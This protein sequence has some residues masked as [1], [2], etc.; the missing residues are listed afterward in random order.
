MTALDVGAIIKLWPPV[1][2][3]R[4]SASL[5]ILRTASRERNSR[6]AILCTVVSPD[7]ASSS[8]ERLR[9]ALDNANGECTLLIESRILLVEWNLFA[10]STYLMIQTPRPRK[11]MLKTILVRCWRGRAT[12]LHT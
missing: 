9:A 7:S 1:P 3:H 6:V 11:R 2:N 5:S 10:G 4:V 8:R 12:T